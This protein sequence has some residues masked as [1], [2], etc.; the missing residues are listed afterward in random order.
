MQRAKRSSLNKLVSLRQN[1]MKNEMYVLHIRKCY[2]AKELDYLL[3]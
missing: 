2:K 3:A 1:E